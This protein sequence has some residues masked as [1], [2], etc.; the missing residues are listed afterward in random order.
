MNCKCWDQVDAMLKD[1]NLKLSD[2]PLVLMLPNLQTGIVFKTRWIDPAKA[3][4]GK[5]K[6]PPTMRAEHC[7]FCG[8]KI[9]AEKPAESE[10]KG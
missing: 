1:Q 4:K 8:V 6:S 2:E 10:A 5:K 9:Q 7:P 3:P